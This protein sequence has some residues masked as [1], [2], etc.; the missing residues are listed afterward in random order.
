M[1]APM[2]EIRNVGKRYSVGRG[3]FATRRTLT[4]VGRNPRKIRTTPT[5]ATR[6][7]GGTNRWGTR[8][9]SSK[10]SMGPSKRQKT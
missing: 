7:A 4:A 3:M 9:Q 6:P 1:P 8:S 2:I 5:I 10:S